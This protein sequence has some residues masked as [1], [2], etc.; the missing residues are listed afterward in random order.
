MYHKLPGSKKIVSWNGTFSALCKSTFPKET[1]HTDQ[2]L[3]DIRKWHKFYF[4]TLHAVL[5]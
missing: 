5:Y 2:K 4:G 1:S 3:K